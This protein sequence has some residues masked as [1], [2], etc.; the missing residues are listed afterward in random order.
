VDSLIH[1]GLAHDY[2]PTDADFEGGVRAI[3]S[4]EPADD[5]R[6]E[7]EAHPPSLAQKDVGYASGSTADFARPKSSLSR[8]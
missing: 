1:N 6:S 7:E 3:H 2:V 8:R 5:A 4:D